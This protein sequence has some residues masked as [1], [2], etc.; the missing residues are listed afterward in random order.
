MSIPSAPSNNSNATTFPV[1]APSPSSDPSASD[2]KSAAA[3][4]RP[5]NNEKKRK[6]NGAAATSSRGVANLTPEQLAKKRANDREAQRAIRERTKNQ[7]ETLERRIQE[8]TSQQPYQELQHA[9]RQK[10]LV[11][12]E[13][14]EI[15]RRLF[16][17]L[18]LIKPVVGNSASG[19]MRSLQP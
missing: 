4:R 2:H 7:I 16:T 9:L 13:N 18:E 19:G 1:E 15:K 5:N 17:V 11:E 12:A 14:A 10:E 6:A 8:L 3:G